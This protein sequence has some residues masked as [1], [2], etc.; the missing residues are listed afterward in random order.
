MNRFWLISPLALAACTPPVPVAEDFIPEY[1]GVETVLLDGDLVQFN[2]AMTKALSDADVQRYAECAAAQ[3]TLI[4]GYG[5]A[6]HL[7]TNVNEEGGVWSADAVYTISPTLPDGFA[8]IDAE[9]VVAAC[10]ES[11]IPTV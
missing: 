2:V 1:L 4:R 6:R 9:V 11:G 3:Y 10:E 8:K 5:F 7:R